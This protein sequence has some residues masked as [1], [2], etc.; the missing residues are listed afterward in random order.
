MATITNNERAPIALPTGHVIPRLGT[1]TTDNATIRQPDNWPNLSG[2]ALAGQITIAFDP[3]PDPAEPEQ[4]VT[5][6][7]TP[8][9]PTSVLQL[10][11]TSPPLPG[12]PAS[13]S[14]DEGKRK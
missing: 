1:L 14:T 11:T 5:Q 10:I 6:T 2:R 13:K 7:V 8:H 12:T 4:T 9:E 3:D